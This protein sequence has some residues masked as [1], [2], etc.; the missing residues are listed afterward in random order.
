MLV[1]V[2]QDTISLKTSLLWAKRKNGAEHILARRPRDPS[3]P[4]SRA[5]NGTFLSGVRV[6][7]C[8]PSSLP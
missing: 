1:E 4:D 8:P 7:P 3:D 6:D 2:A 5:C